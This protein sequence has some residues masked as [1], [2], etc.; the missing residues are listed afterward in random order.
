ME[1]GHYGKQLI[2]KSEITEYVEKRNGGGK[3][4]SQQKVFWTTD[5]KTE[6]PYKGGYY[7]RSDISKF[8]KRLESNG[9]SVKGIVVD[10][11]YN[12]ELIVELNEEEE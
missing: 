8:I 12:I 2:E 5:V 10:D 1:R 9:E 7:H 4:M 6:T 3:E 11:S